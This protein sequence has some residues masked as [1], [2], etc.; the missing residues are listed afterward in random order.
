[1]RDYIYISDKNRSVVKMELVLAVKLKES[2]VQYI[3]Y[4]KEDNNSRIYVAKIGEEHANVLDTN[5]TEEERN[6]I[7]ELLEKQLREIK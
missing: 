2:N 7:E 6:M 5:V 3:L 4:K 1:M